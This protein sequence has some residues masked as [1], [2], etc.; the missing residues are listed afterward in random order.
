MAYINTDISSYFPLYE[1]HA[2]TKNVY[3]C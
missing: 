2:H 3:L 1:N